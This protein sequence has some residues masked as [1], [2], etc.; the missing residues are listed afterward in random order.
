MRAG[1]RRAGPCPCGRRELRA[2]QEGVVRCLVSAANRVLA[3]SL[4]STH[5]RGLSAVAERYLTVLRVRARPLAEPRY[6]PVSPAQFWVDVDQQCRSRPSLGPIM[7]R[8]GKGVIEPG[9]GAVPDGHAPRG[10]FID[11][12]LE[13]GDSPW[14]VSTRRCRRDREPGRRAPRYRNSRTSARRPHAGCKVDQAVEG[15]DGASIELSA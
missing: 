9:D 13:V 4:W 15:T 10:E 11:C 3:C 6:H 7:R 14:R 5:G 2:A 1:G 12:A 8:F